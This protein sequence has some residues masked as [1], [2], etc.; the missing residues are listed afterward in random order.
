MTTP[1]DRDAAGRARNA[2]PRDASGRPL[3]RGAAEGVERVPDDLVL[4]PDEAVTRA[5]ELLDAGRPFTAHEVLEGAW[6][7]ADEPDR[8]LWRALAQLAVGLTHAQRGNARG[9][10]ALLDRG[11][12]NLARWVGPVPAGLDVRGLLAHADALARRI[13]RD[14][15]A[16]ITE[17]DLSLH[18]REG[19]V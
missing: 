2:R 19:A 17:R 6:K 1:R 12:G 5:Q 13:E 14:G 7:A 15:L 9:A 16:G 4:T 11:A 8:E 10:V 3:P 18:L